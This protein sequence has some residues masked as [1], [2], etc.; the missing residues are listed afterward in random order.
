MAKELDPQDFY[1]RTEPGIDPPDSEPVT[2]TAERLPND[3]QPPATEEFAPANYPVSQSEFERLTGVKRQTFGNHIKAI[4]T[5][6]GR[7]GSCLDDQRRVTEQG[8]K[9]LKGYWEATDKLSYL[10]E[11]KA[12]LQDEAMSGGSSLAITTAASTT[13]NSA[14]VA[15]R[16]RV[17]AWNAN[18]ESQVQQ[19]MEN[20]RSIANAQH[21][22]VEISEIEQEALDHQLD[23][24]CLSE[25]AAETQ[26]RTAKKAKRKAELRVQLGLAA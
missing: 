26:T 16:E 17:T 24:E 15:E 12:Q 2:V 11:L 1:D 13:M 6:L 20:L 23:L 7:L 3:C 14:I 4:D 8:A 25:I 9:W 10:D 18:L 19:A 21:E 5:H 22:A